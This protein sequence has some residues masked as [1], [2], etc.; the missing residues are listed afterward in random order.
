MPLGPNKYAISVLHKS[1]LFFLHSCVGLFCHISFYILSALG[2]ASLQS[3]LSAR[4]C[5]QHLKLIRLNG[6]SSAQQYMRLFC[7]VWQYRLSTSAGLLTPSEI[8]LMAGQ[9]FG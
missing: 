3:V 2:F 7:F 1:P 9:G 6:G 4:G 8:E 5:Q